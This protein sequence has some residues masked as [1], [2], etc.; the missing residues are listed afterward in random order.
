MTQINVQDSDFQHDIA[1]DSENHNNFF[2]HSATSNPYIK[3]LE[4]NSKLHII[5]ETKAIS[6]WRS[7][8]YVGLLPLLVCFFELMVDGR[9]SIV[10]GRW[11][12]EVDVDDKKTRL[13]YTKVPVLLIYFANI[14][15]IMFFLSECFVFA[16]G[17]VY[18]T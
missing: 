7:K 4:N 11:S 5:Q 12:I 13:S 1:L 8:G 10:D 6:L 3:K 14:R 17:I 9:L 16:L 2:R 15:G 18:N